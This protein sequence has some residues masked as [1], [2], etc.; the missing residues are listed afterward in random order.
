[1]YHPRQASQKKEKK[2]RTKR[3][4]SRRKKEKKKE[5]NKRRTKKEG[6]APVPPDICV[7][8][9]AYLLNFLKGKQVSELIRRLYRN[10]ILKNTVKF[11]IMVMYDIKRGLLWIYSRK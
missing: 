10:F 3:R 2:K 1:M 5:S 4:K 6:H 11:D 7:A 8:H 9:K